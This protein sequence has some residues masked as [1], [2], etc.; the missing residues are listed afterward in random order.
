MRIKGYGVTGRR[1]YLFDITIDEIEDGRWTTHQIGARNLFGT[2]DEVVRE[3]VRAN[4]ARARAFAQE[5]IAADMI[6]DIFDQLAVRRA[7]AFIDAD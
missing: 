3:I 1:R 7:L 5:E 6:G 2:Y 4:E